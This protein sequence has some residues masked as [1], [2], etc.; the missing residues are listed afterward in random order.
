MSQMSFGPLHVSISQGVSWVI[1][2]GPSCGETPTQQ[3]HAQQELVVQQRTS[4]AL[5]VR[6]AVTICDGARPQCFL[7]SAPNEA[8][9]GE[10]PTIDNS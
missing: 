9:N 10:H 3:M 8:G 2:A 4:P 6:E 5:P 7:A 1:L